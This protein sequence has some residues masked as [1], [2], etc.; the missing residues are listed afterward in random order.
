MLT[1]CNKLQRWNILEVVEESGGGKDAE[2]PRRHSHAERGN[3][4][5]E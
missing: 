4:S 1:M 2:R 5:A 3:D